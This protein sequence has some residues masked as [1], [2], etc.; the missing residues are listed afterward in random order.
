MNNLDK[1]QKSK[2]EEKDIRELR[3]INE[4]YKLQ[5]KLYEQA[6]D[7]FDSN[8]IKEF[9][10]LMKFIKTPVVLE[11]A[12]KNISQNHGANTPGPDG[13]TCKDYLKMNRNE[14]IRQFQ[15]DLEWYE[16]GQVKR[17]EIP[18][19]NGKLR[20]L[21]IPNVR[22]RIIQEAVRMIVEPIAEAQM[23]EYSY[24]FRPFR[25]PGNAITYAKQCFTSTQ[26]TWVVE[27]DIKGFFDNI[28]HSIMLKSL[29][30]IGIKDR[31]LLMI[32]KQML[33]AGIFNL[34]EVNEIGTPQGGIISPL[35]ANVYLNGFDHWINNQWR[36]KKTKETY[37]RPDVK[38]FALKK[39]NL[40]PMYLVRYAD[41]WMIITDSYQHA[42]KIK[43]MTKKFFAEKLKLELSDE[44]TLITNI[45]KKKAKFLGV[46]IFSKPNNKKTSW[47]KYSTHTKPNE[48]KLIGKVNDIKKDIQE[49][50]KHTN[51]SKEELITRVN[52]VNTKIRGLINY[53]N[54]CTDASIVFKKMDR[55]L[56]FAS[57]RLA[58]KCGGKLIPAKETINL[59]SVHS[60]YS[61]KINAIEYKGSWVGITSLCFLK[62]ERKIRKLDENRYTVEG[63]KIRADRQQ[64]RPIQLRAEELLT[65]T[66][67][68]FGEMHDDIHNVEYYMNRINTYIRDHGKCRCC[69]NV[70]YRNVRIHHINSKLSMEKVNKIPNLLTT[71]EKCHSL[72]HSNSDCN[73]YN[74][75]MRKN[76][77]K[78]RKKFYTTEK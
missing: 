54:V 7:G 34:M 5:D 30:R 46:E 38:T 63:R 47:Q 31:K 43:E 53:Y 16:A 12:L 49:I 55:R 68:E 65:D 66:M 32:I 28:N 26:Y 17:V 70:I 6:K 9:K 44:K 10:N 33:K 74:E 50:A 13:K 3:Q 40:I 14:Y 78:Y 36:N 23:Y 45:S 37:S 73:E 52:I 69:Q 64:K 42:N 8:D 4:L 24:G 75:K 41:D 18:K 59:P 56:L 62:F 67:I 35:L 71:C 15:K 22:D 2:T 72:L 48:E 39:T 27:G 25:T 58:Y 60:K 19:A 21:G 29:K 51:N 20:P 77:L 1:K 76:I 61:Q 57:A 11:L